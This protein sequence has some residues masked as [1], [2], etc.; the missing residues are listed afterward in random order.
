MPGSMTDAEL[1]AVEMIAMAMGKLPL[2]PSRPGPLLI[3]AD[4]TFECHGP[5]C[6]GGMVVFHSD[7]VLE[8]CVRNPQIRTRHACPRCFTH[9]SEPALVEHACTG[10]L[11]EHDDGQVECTAGDA[12]LGRHAIHMSRRSCR[13]FG[14][15]ARNCGGTSV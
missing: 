4:G 13:M 3:H 9:S 5:Q 14:P 2:Q 7:D 11:I 12:C 6:P 15:C 10:Q 8:P 1:T